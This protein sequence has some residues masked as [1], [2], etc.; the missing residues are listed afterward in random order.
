MINNSI[1]FGA[2]LVST[3]NIKQFD[4]IRKSYHPQKVS[5]VELDPTDYTDLQAVKKVAEN[6]HDAQYAASISGIVHSIFAHFIDKKEHAIYAITT[7]NKNHGKLNNK[8]ILA[9]AEVNT[10]KD[11]RINLDYLQVN[12]NFMYLAKNK[13]FKGIGKCMLDFLKNTY[14]KIITLRSDYKAIPFYEKNGFTILEPGKLEY[15]W[16]PFKG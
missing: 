3:D 6:W 16:F 5:I 9:L 8:K 4:W 15:F 13:K 12:P 2:R 1:T 11:D 10:S 7:Q 14:N